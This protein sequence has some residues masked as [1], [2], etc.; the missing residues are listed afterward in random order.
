LARARTL[1]AQGRL[2]DAI[3][4]LDLV[5]PTDAQKPDADRLRGEIQRQLISLG[6]LDS[7]EGRSR[8]P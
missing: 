5:R 8:T 2:H 3:A 7:G 6:S 1:S 4:A